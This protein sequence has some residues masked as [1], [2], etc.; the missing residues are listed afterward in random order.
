MSTR[1]SQVHLDIGSRF[2]NIDLVQIVMETSLRQLDFDE[3]T[4]HRIGLSVREAVANAIKHGNRLDPDK[5]VSIELDVSKDELMIKI[6]DEGEGF[7]P[8]KLPDPLSKE[9]L[10]RPNG[11]GI[12]FMTSFMDEI[13]YSFVNNKGM[14]VTMRKSLAAP[15]ADPSEQEEND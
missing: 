4:S 15:S 12:L 11:R 10:L 7:D 5:R 13:D 9:N 2:E 1:E 14:V 3:Q 8:G 6:S